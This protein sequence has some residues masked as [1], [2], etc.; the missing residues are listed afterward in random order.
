MIGLPF[1]IKI[2]FDLKTVSSCWGDFLIEWRYIYLEQYLCCCCKAELVS[3]LA[4]SKPSNSPEPKV[5][6]NYN[7]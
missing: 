3:T 1:E 6:L 7:L 2:K 4:A 5:N